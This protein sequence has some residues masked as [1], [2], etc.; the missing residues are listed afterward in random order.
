MKRPS[1]EL[2]KVHEGN[3][4]Y[5]ERAQLLW[6]IGGQVWSSSS[7]TRVVSRRWH[8][9][10]RGGQKCGGTFHGAAE[11]TVT[12]THVRHL[13]GFLKLLGEITVLK[14]NQNICNW[15]WEQNTERPFVINPTTSYFHPGNNSA[16]ENSEYQQIQEKITAQGCSSVTWEN[17]AVSMKLQ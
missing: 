16:W 10:A 8:G 11:R 17:E 1:K 7:G 12:W 9:G 14:W 5:S 3:Q 4:S 13:L 15:E 6:D 2:H